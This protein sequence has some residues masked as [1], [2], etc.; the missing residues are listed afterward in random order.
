MA[1]APNAFNAAAR[2]EVHPEIILGYITVI[3]IYIYIYVCVYIYIYI[4]VYICMYVCMYVCV[5]IYVCVC[6]CVRE[7]NRCDSFTY[8]EC[9]KKKTYN[10][11]NAINIY[12]GT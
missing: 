1:G 12:Q 4:Y 9:V 10:N 8:T 7:L 2:I 11:C 6:V 3:Y 5:Y